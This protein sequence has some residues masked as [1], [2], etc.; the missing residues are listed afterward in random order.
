MKLRSEDRQTIVSD[1]LD[2]GDRAERCVMLAADEAAQDLQ[3]NQWYESGNWLMHQGLICKNDD[4]LLLVPPAINVE[5][6]IGHG[7]SWIVIWVD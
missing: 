7:A 6:F 2:D 5:S 4:W 3:K 1:V